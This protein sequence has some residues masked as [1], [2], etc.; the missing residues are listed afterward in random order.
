[1]TGPETKQREQ[2]QSTQSNFSKAV[3]AGRLC[4]RVSLASRPLAPLA[5]SLGCVGGVS[6]V[7]SVGCATAWELELFLR[8]AKA[9]SIVLGSK[10][11]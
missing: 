3:S 4:P 10:K 9:V 11:T 2:T 7:G 6:G 1:M 5:V 8:Q